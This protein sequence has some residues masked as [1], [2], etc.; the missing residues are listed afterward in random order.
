VHTSFAAVAYDEG[1]RILT[2]Q[3]LLTQLLTQLLTHLMA[4][5]AKI[6]KSMRASTNNEIPLL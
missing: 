4:Q 1:S 3:H 2:T 6:I 5:S